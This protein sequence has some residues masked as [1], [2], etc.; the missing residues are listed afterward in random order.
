VRCL[1]CYVSKG[2]TS[3]GEGTCLRMTRAL[4]SRVVFSQHADFQE[5]QPCERLHVHFLSDCS[6]NPVLGARCFPL[7][8]PLVGEKEA[9]GELM[10]ARPP[11]SLVH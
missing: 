7:T 4:I 1:L 10:P 6:S 11:V 2:T 9:V 3:K 5:I 8:G